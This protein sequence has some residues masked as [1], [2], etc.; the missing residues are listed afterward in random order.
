MDH[1]VLHKLTLLIMSMNPRLDQSGA[2]PCRIWKVM[3]MLNIITSYLFP[4]TTGNK[5]DSVFHGCSLVNK[6]SWDL[7][8][9]ILGLISSC[10]RG[11]QGKLPL[12]Q[13]DG[14]CLLLGYT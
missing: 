4:A 3:L 14:P 13:D 7:W 12:Q 11:Y 8:E 10:N 5:V 1:F 9:S 6:I 2:L